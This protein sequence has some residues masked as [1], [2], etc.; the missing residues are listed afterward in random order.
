V[1][2]GGGGTLNVLDGL[3]IWDLGWGNRCVGGS[4]VAPRG[5]RSLDGAQCV[6]RGAIVGVGIADVAMN[7]PWWRL[8]D[9]LRLLDG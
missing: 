5:W 9:G 2:I 6:V 8:V 3:T 4:V 1:V 7:G